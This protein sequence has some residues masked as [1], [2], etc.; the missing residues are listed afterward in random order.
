MYGALCSIHHMCGSDVHWY[1]HYDI[2]YL[3]GPIISHWSCCGMWV[4]VFWLKCWWGIEHTQRDCVSVYIPTPS[5]LHTC[6]TLSHW[7]SEEH[8]ISFHWALLLWL[9]PPIGRACEYCQKLCI[10]KAKVIAGFQKQFLYQLAGVCT[11]LAVAGAM[12]CFFTKCAHFHSVFLPFHNRFLLLSCVHISVIKLASTVS[13]LDNWY[14]VCVHF[15]SPLSSLP[16]LP[17][18]PI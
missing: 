18:L 4:G 16:P 11:V 5:S 7:N 10:L 13:E 14:V 3:F 12:H 2:Y 8:F 9:W 1:C 6:P 15:R 17:S